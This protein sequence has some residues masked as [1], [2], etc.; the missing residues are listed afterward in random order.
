VGWL[1]ACPRD[2][3]RACCADCW[4]STLVAANTDKPP[5]S[6]PTNKPQENFV[7]SFRYFDEIKVIQLASKGV[8]PGIVRS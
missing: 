6:R 4:A 5:A 7:P 1:K 3:C 8:L 2:C